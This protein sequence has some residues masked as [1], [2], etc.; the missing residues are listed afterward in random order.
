LHP[1]A[2]P[3]S[4]SLPLHGTGPPAASAPLSRL[5]SFTRRVLTVKSGLALA[6]VPGQPRPEGQVRP[7]SGPGPGAAA[8]R[9]SSS[10]WFWPWSRGSRV[11]DGQVRPGSGPGPGAAAARGQQLV[12]GPRVCC[13]PLGGRLAPGGDRSASASGC[14]WQ[15]VEGSNLNSPVCTVCWLPR[16]PVGVQ[17]MMM[18]PPQMGAGPTCG[19]AAAPSRGVWH[20]EGKGRATLQGGLHM[21]PVRPCCSCVDVLPAPVVASGYDAWGLPA[22]RCCRMH[23]TRCR[24]PMPAWP[25]A[26]SA[27]SAW[28]VKGLH[29]L[30]AC[31]ACQRSELTPPTCGN[32]PPA[33]CAAAT[34]SGS[35]GGGCKAG[36]GTANAGDDGGWCCCGGPYE[37][38]RAT[39]PTTRWLTAENAG[40]VNAREASP[41][42]ICVCDCE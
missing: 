16:I 15:W 21:L 37:D 3:P 41:T 36:R 34:G 2:R 28:L 31:I 13:G 32:W 4:Q 18:P 24:S 7:G 33:V 5:P 22:A 17:A 23:T 35:V 1:G 27:P 9:G 10:A 14:Q 30:K 6:L 40:G 12:R 29:R 26:T 8:A 25:A 42:A 11:P 39:G 20:R 38:A 19:C